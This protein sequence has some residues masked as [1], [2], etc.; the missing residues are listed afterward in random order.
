MP[1]QETAD[2]RQERRSAVKTICRLSTALQ[3]PEKL[4]RDV[5]G[6]VLAERV[7]QLRDASLCLK[8][9]RVFGFRN[10]VGCAVVVG[11]ITNISI[12]CVC[13]VSLC[14]KLSFW[15]SVFQQPAYSYWA[16]YDV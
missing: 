14:F 2:Q 9:E 13:P 15:D 12:C 7:A 10:L 16:V 4:S 11:A 3:S 6:E 1:V 8:S 5:G